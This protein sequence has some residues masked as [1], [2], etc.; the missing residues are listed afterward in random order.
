M[1]A[2]AIRRGASVGD[3]NAS[4]GQEFRAETD[5]TSS[6]SPSCNTKIERVLGK[7]HEYARL[8][9]ED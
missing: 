2:R 5:L 1:M 9:R 8:E 6:Q 4:R 7:A 3:L